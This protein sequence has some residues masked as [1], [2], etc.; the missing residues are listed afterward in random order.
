MQIRNLQETS[1]PE[2]VDCLLQAFEGYFVKMPDD[3]LYWQNRFTAARVDW[4]LSFGMFD[5]NRLIAF[6]I[7]G[8]D[9]ENDTL[10]AFNTGTGV[11]PQFRGQKIVD[12]L[13]AFA[14][15]L[16]KKS[17]IEACSLEVIQTN[18][19]AVSVYKRIGFSITKEYNCYNGIL[20]VPETNGTVSEISIDEI[21]EKENPNHPFY[22]WDHR[23]EAINLAR[24]NYKAYSFQC[25]TGAGYFILNPG[26]GYLAQLEIEPET[27]ENYMQLLSGI[28][29]ISSAVRINNVDSRRILLRESLVKASLDNTVDQFQMRMGLG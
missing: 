3:L 22:S 27:A 18:A 11:L 10:T 16:L 7:H 28:R 24:K 14:F 17:G 4:E 6:I 21:F 23:N 12:Q 19:I 26:T 9:F 29:K 8:I 5:G 25:E 13:Y 2:I 20:H 15:P 1:L